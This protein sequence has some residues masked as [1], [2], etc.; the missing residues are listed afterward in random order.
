VYKVAGKVFLLLSLDGQ[1]LEGLSFKCTLDEFD[2]LTEID[3][4]VQAPYFAKR[5][6]VK[7]EDPSALPEAQLTARIR[8]SYDLVAAGLPKKIRQELG[9]AN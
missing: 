5:L 7:L 8:R 3:G 1:V 9:L 6:W 4:I 2:A